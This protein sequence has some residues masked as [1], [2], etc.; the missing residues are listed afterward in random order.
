[1]PMP[2]ERQ[3]Q[4]S[5]ARLRRT[6]RVLAITGPRQSGKTTL[7]RMCFADKPY[8]SFEDV[9]VRQRAQADP[10][11]FL[12]QFPDGAV[13]DEVQRL[14]GILSNLQGLVDDRQR[15]GDFVLT[16]SEQ[17][18]LRAGISQSLAGRVAHLELLPLSLAEI[19]QTPAWQ[20]K[21][22]PDLM[23]I[24]WRGAYPALIAPD[25]AAPEPYDWYAQYFAT[26]V[27]RDVRQITGVH[28][29][30]AFERFVMLCA[31]RCGQLLNTASL[32]SDAGVSVNTA[33]HWLS[34]LQASYIIR[35]LQPWH[36]NFG[37]R[38]V[39][40]PK[41]YFY[42]TGLLCHLLRIA[43]A[44]TLSTHAMRGAVFESWVVSETL[45]HRLN[46]GLAPDVYFWRDNPGTE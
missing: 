30:A 16:G 41:L 31:G 11:G 18:G 20:R 33:K 4:F 27:Q 14:P 45:K 24:L 35:L 8:V 42:D 2:I 9:D 28:D 37:K 32:A 22:S 12:A 34:V 25:D 1:M 36:E 43:D 19:A 38:L 6:F 26:Y 5:I 17:F 39:K 46:Q 15:M 40:M 29:L 10:R 44:Q 13:F 21:P 3:A 7:A 23:Q